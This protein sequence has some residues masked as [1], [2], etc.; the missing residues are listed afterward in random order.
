MR[1]LLKL[2][3]VAAIV[4]AAVWGYPSS[5]AAFP[6]TCGSIPSCSVINGEACKTSTVC[7]IGGRPLLECSCVSGHYHCP[8]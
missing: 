4:A 6:T 8:L 7:C 2:L 1:S 3:V 5:V